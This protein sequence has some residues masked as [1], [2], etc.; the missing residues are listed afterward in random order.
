MDLGTL[1]ATLGGV[2]ALIGAAVSVVY[3]RVQGIS[4]TTDTL[5]Q[6]IDT[7][8]EDNKAKDTLIM[9]LKEQVKTLTDLVTSKADVE[10]VKLQLD[11]VQATLN[12]IAEKVGVVGS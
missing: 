1:L 12:L 5:R 4:G 10:T 6:R 11:K 8:A 3:T 7:L 9:D 2:G